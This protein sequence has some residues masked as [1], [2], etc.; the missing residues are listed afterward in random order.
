M[1]RTS[2]ADVK[3]SMF[4]HM[5]TVLHTEPVMTSSMAHV[6]VSTVFPPVGN[7]ASREKVI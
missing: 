7:T 4:G 5:L 3:I 2:S 1:G 6:G